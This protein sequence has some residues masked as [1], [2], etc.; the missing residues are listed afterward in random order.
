[1]R[2]VISLAAFALVAACTSTPADQ[3]ETIPTSGTTRAQQP[4]TTLPAPTTQPEIRSEFCRVLDEIAAE[5]A[6]VQQR[7]ETSDPLAGLFLIAGAVGDIHASLDRLAAVAPDE[8]R[9]D[10]DGLS[11][12]FNIDV[13]EA[14]SNPLGALAQSIASGLIQQNSI[15]RVDAY[16][17]QECGM[18]VIGTTTISATKELSPRKEGDIHVV[19]MTNIWGE[20]VCSADT[21]PRDI[22]NG[23]LTGVC[24]NT[25]FGFALEELR[26]LWKHTF[27]Q[28]LEVTS[29]GVGGDVASFITHEVIPQSGLTAERLSVKLHTF[30][31]QTGVQGTSSEVQLPEGQPTEGTNEPEEF[32]ASMLES[33]QI[34]SVTS[35]GVTLVDSPNQYACGQRLPRGAQAFDRDGTVVWQSDHI[36]GLYHDYALAALGNDRGDC[37]DDAP[38]LL[39]I[40][41][42]NTGDVIHENGAYALPD[43]S[44]CGSWIQTQEHRFNTDPPYGYT[45]LET[46]ETVIA[47]QGAA[48]VSPLREGAVVAEDG[49]LLFVGSGGEVGWSLDSEVTANRSVISGQLIITDG[50]GANIVV[51]QATGEEAS[52]VSE[53][54][55]ALFDSGRWEYVET[56]AASG[57]RIAD[58]LWHCDE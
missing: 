21:G 34:V 50:T 16:A 32:L 31:M 20:P 38:Y 37:G 49:D 39:Q 26:L 42:A 45:N 5:N 58:E 25:V 27:P 52:R 23:V 43:P 44:Q 29:W 15:Q 2:R 12:A 9:S 19:D 56:T 36:W 17:Q 33:L 55:E 24:G 35:E 7:V 47:P 28:P 18:P 53:L 8:I 57:W 13:S 54:P 3:P 48:P 46:L 1:M 41:D 6:A 40:V 30:D 22:S 11:E 10:L 51:D 4:T 14:V